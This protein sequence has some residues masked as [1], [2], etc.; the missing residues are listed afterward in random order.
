MASNTDEV[1]NLK[2]QISDAQF[3]E[4]GR[5]FIELGQVPD[6][7]ADGFK[8]LSEKVQK[9]AAILLGKEKLESST[10]TKNGKNLLATYKETA[11]LHSPTFQ[12][13]ST[14]Q[15]SPSPL[16]SS[17][18]PAFFSQPHVQ[19]RSQPAQASVLPEKAIG[20]YIVKLAQIQQA[21]DLSIDQKLQLLLQLQDMADPFMR[22]H[23]NS[24]DLPLR[25]SVRSFRQNLDRFI[26][27]NTIAPLLRK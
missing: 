11:Q 10:L 23:E 26:G 7:P 8:K 16:S 9:D 3:E 17:S 15:V 14:P 4:I 22:T 5:G 19:A 6:F 21:P 24:S 1:R 18:S 12:A 2:E 27:E 25:E 13:A 20:G